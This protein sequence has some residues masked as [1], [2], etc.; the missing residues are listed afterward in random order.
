[1][2]VEEIHTVWMNV[3]LESLQPVIAQSEHVRLDLEA[4]SRFSREIVTA[5]QDASTW[6][7]AY[8]FSDGTEKTVAYVL[9]LDALNFCFWGD[10]RWQVVRDGQTLSGYLALAA[11]LKRAIIEKIPITDA[12]FLSEISE[13]KLSQILRGQ[14]RLHL[15]EKRLEILRET[16]AVLLKKYQGHAHYL[17]EAAQQSA[18]RLIQLLAQDFP[19]FR[20]EATYKGKG[21]LFFKRAQI[22]AAD[23][24][25]AFYGRRWG[26]FDD[27]DQLTAFADYKLP[28]VLRHLGILQYDPSLAG[29]IDRQELLMPGSPEEVEIRA[30]TLWAVELLRRKLAAQNYPWHAYEI[31]W[32]LWNLG[33]DDAY[34]VKPYHRTITIYY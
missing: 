4:L 17:V 13:K 34:R 27:L 5:N 12:R 19:S 21:V 9:V 2:S 14:G 24:Y 26:A 22:L 32:M 29:K 25:G 7:N 20:D 3:I 23:L 6:N 15:W 33:Q 31:D 10:P 16:G 28:Q 30:H 11:A 8:H 1:V 18:V